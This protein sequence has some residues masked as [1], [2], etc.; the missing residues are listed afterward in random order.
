MKQITLEI[1][2]KLYIKAGGETSHSANEWW[3]IHNEME[4]VIA[5]P[6]D[7]AAA[8]VIGWW[9]CWDD[10]YT[11]IKFARRVR[12]YHAMI[13]IKVKNYEPSN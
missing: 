1:A 12:K 3:Y 4:A 7:R 9:D 6:S 13:Y 8:N 11:A 10:K 2:K 5:A